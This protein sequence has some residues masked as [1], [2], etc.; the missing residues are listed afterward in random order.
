MWATRKLSGTWFYWTPAVSPVAVPTLI[1][2]IV[3]T[4]SKNGLVLMN[5]A[6]RGDGTLPEV[7]AAPLRSIGDW[8]AINGEGIYGTRPWKIFGEGPKKISDERQG[9]NLEPYSAADIRFTTKDGHLYAF[10]LAPPTEDIL[11]KTLGT[12]GPLKEQ[13]TS[14]VLLGSSETLKWSRSTAGLTIKRPESLPCQYVAGLRIT[15]K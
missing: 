14:I 4:V 13:I 7:Q 2:N 8:L 10:V 6:L 3:D 12:G 5:I 15:L 11:I 9:E 1:G